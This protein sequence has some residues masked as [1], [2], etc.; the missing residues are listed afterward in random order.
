MKDSALI[1]IS[2][3]IK[4]AAGF[5]LAACVLLYAGAA[6]SDD[7]ELLSVEKKEDKSQALLRVVCDAPALFSSYLTTSP[8][9]LALEIPQVK[10]ACDSCVG[11]LNLGG[12]SVQMDYKSDSRLYKM[13][14]PLPTDVDYDIRQDGGAIVVI[15]FAPSG[16]QFTVSK[17]NPPDD[18]IKPKAK[19]EIKIGQLGGKDAAEKKKSVETPSADADKAG[20]MNVLREILAKKDS[21][22]ETPKTEE[23]VSNNV[24]IA[25][26]TES[27]E[28]KT[29]ITDEIKPIDTLKTVETKADKSQ[30]KNEPAVSDVKTEQ[31]SGK[32]ET[33][34]KIAV[35]GVPKGGTTKEKTEPQKDEIKIA[36]K[37]EEK[38]ETDGKI[39]EKIAVISQEKEEKKKEKSKDE[40]KT[41]VSLLDKTLT[42][43][44][45]DKGE[46]PEKTAKKE[47]EK[48]GQKSEVT[49]KNES[50][51]PNLPMTKI[52]LPDKNKTEKNV[53]KDGFEKVKDT[54]QKT[55][56]IE[57][58][59]KIDKTQTAV[60]TEKSEKTEKL[61]SDGKIGKE[62]KSV[63][64]VMNYNFATPEDSTPLESFESYVKDGKTFVVLRTRDPVRY[65][66][67]IA[68]G[69]AV[70][71]KLFAAKIIKKMHIFPINGPT[72]G[73]AIKIYPAY[74]ASEYAVEFL[75]S[76]NENSKVRF[77]RSDDGRTI[78]IEIE[79]NY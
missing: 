65:K 15:L 35:N 44:K 19:E 40:A 55:A 28:K 50:A 62:R 20:E 54:Q 56:K 39:E 47:N 30:I 79:P 63:A 4:T 32:I 57:K 67:A 42:P 24:K 22:K 78:V 66:A 23:E 6:H 36:A 76:L 7:R 49:A 71:V 77:S 69:S 43:Q 29:P 68:E 1:K 48:T 61:E 53:S 74:R 41:K 26:K 75:I 34:V 17:Q 18:R 38:K 12:I 5:A 16:T 58:S 37:T 10:H 2:A 27:T 8:Q 21:K 60:K 33:D 51:I 46:A 72:G 45:I 25:Q 59:D 11:A 3:K 31:K 52:T 14:I 9:A 70:R 73:A 13:I 64:A